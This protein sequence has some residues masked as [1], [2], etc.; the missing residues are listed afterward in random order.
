[1]TRG[2][3]LGRKVI[4]L[5]D[6]KGIQKYVHRPKDLG[7][8]AAELHAVDYI[9]IQPYRRS[10]K[11]KAL[12]DSI[13]KQVGTRK[14]DEMHELLSVLSD[15]DMDVQQ[16][17]DDF[18][19]KHPDLSR[20]SALKLG[21]ID[22]PWHVYKHKLAVA[23]PELLYT[24]DK[25]FI[26]IGMAKG[27]PKD[28]LIDMIL[29]NTNPIEYGGIMPTLMSAANE[30]YPRSWFSAFYKDI[31]L[32]PSAKKYYQKMTYTLKDKIFYIGE[33]VDE[34]LL[35]PSEQQRLIKLMLAGKVPFGKS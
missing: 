17:Y 9:L 26:H 23:E 28:A 3:G 15:H 14:F 16:F 32:N 4:P 13:I 31:K 10:R 30:E 2:K 27:Y 11:L 35:K 29:L 33:G 18:K 24:R 7:F 34:V 8:S 20:I 21:L 1:M 19:A 25:V 12:Q 5:N 22:I 6:T